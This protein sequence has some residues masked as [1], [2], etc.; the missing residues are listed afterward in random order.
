MES[1]EIR[2]WDLYNR[3]NWN[4]YDLM[5]SYKVV[6]LIFKNWFPSKNIV[7]RVI[8]EIENINGSATD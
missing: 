8:Q 3:C 6:N 7:W 5:N 1:S 4:D 2:S